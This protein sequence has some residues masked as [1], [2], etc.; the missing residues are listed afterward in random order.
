MI[1][2]NCMDLQKLDTAI[3][4]DHYIFFRFKSLRLVSFEL[5]MNCLGSV[6]IFCKIVSIVA[7]S[8]LQVTNA[9]LDF[10]IT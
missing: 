1:F 5:S 3:M 7:F 10:H 8:E 4:S 6:N 9:S 2:I